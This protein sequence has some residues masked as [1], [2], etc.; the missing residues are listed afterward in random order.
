LSVAEQAECSDRDATPADRSGR[1]R[2]ELSLWPVV[3]EEAFPAAAS[4]PE[5][6]LHRMATC[7]RLYS[8]QISPTETLA[9]RGGHFS[10]DKAARDRFLSTKD[11]QYVKAL[12]VMGYR[13]EAARLVH[14]A[15]AKRKTERETASASEQQRF[16]RPTLFTRFDIDY[17]EMLILVGD[18]RAAMDLFL[19]AMDDYELDRLG[20]IVRRVD[21]E[22]MLEMEYRETM[23]AIEAG[24]SLAG[25]VGPEKAKDQRRAPLR[26]LLRRLFGLTPMGEPLGRGR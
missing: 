24:R 13:D 11:R 18:R 21:N 7:V 23:K 15:Y 8:F 17:L 5:R 20:T 22:I 19:R 26:S 9:P 12:V 1:L 4:D 2:S 3:E 10:G 25:C 14:K 6:D 16:G